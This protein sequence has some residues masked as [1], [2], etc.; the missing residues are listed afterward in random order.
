VLYDQE[1]LYGVPVG[2]AVI[3]LPA[4]A[5]WI[6]ETI[7]AGRILAPTD[8]KHSEVSPAL[9]RQRAAKAEL[10]ELELAERRRELVPR[11]EVLR[12]WQTI[13]DELRALAQDAQRRWGDDAHAR[14]IDAIDRLISAFELELKPAPGTSPAGE[15]CAVAGPLFE[16]PARSPEVSDR[17]EG[18]APRRKQ[19]AKRDRRRAP[20]RVRVD[21]RP[22]APA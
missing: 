15:Y 16:S 4:V 21:D 14:V 5:R 18:L 8:D 6:H 22:G 3:S 7:A 13:T 11:P 10:Y 1:E 17:I 20:A 12:T 2:R 9:E 19:K